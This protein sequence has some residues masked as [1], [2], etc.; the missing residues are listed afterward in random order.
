MFVQNM[1]CPLCGDE[2]CAITQ[3][4]I[5]DLLLDLINHG[6]K[7]CGSVPIDFPNNDP[8]NGI[9]TINYVSDRQ[10]CDGVCGAG[11]VVIEIPNIPLPDTSVLGTRPCKQFLK[12]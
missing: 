10:G 1:K 12:E 3:G 11:D 7:G 8:S 5:Y 9:L 2:R 4:R 6:C